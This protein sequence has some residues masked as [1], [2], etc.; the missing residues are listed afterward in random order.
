[1]IKKVFLI[2]LALILFLS[3]QAQDQ[4]KKFA[5]KSGKIEYKLTGSTKGTKT[6]YFDDY[7]NKY[8]EQ[9]KA[10]TEVTVFGVTDR[11]KN[12]KINIINNDRF[13]DIDHVN[14][15]YTKGELPFYNMNQSIYSDMSEAEQKKYNEDII[16]SFGGEKLGSE[17]VLGRNCDKFSIMGS[18]TWVY[19]GI[20][21]KLETHVMGITSNEIAI[22]FEEN[23]SIPNSRFQAPS[24]ISFVDV[25]KQLAMYE[26][27]E[28]YDDSDYD[29]T[30]PVAYPFADFKKA[31][32]SFNPEGYV[33][34]MVMNQDGQHMAMY[35]Q[36]FANIITIIAS[37]KENMEDIPESELKG[38]ETFSHQGK[39]CYYGKISDEEMEG[40]VLII[41]YD[42]F[43]MDIM[44]MTAPAKDKSTMLKWADEFNF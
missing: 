26:G 31:M 17:K 43:D 24:G 35:T 30:K 28:N 29:D 20:G 10:V 14:R 27:M 22:S 4:A 3:M 11:Q 12:D 33:R 21:L 19:K 6:V 36:G 15:K 25:D 37:A 16:R 2:S 1:M 7:G 34:A 32:N 42:E 5:V 8:Y 40:K 18:Y 38:F 39:T 44:I 9:I 23:I 13:W 41:P